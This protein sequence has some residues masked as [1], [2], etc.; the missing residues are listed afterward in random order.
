[1]KKTKK[2]VTAEA[3]V[4]VGFPAGKRDTV[5]SRGVQDALEEPELMQSWERLGEL[6]FR[7]GSRRSEKSAHLPPPPEALFDMGC[8]FGLGTK[9]GNQAWAAARPGPV[10]EEVCRSPGPPQG[11]HV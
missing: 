2:A 6:R 5:K 8:A 7:K 9:A 11:R 4:S 3:Y 10:G 1:M